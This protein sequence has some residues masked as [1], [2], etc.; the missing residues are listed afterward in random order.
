MKNKCYIGIVVIHNQLYV[1]YGPDHD[2]YVELLRISSLTDVR[3]DIEGISKEMGIPVL[4]VLTVQHLKGGC[5][6]WNSPGRL[7]GRGF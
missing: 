5:L 2:H 6:I 1:T 4:T 7:V 3:R